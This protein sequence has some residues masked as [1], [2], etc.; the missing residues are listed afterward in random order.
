MAEKPKCRICLENDVECAFLFC[1]HYV[2]C[3]DCAHKAVQYRTKCPICREDV[4]CI[5]KIYTP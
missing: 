1:G 5:N 3:Q 2:A 4:I